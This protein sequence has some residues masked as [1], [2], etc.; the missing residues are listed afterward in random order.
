[1]EIRNLLTALPLI[2]ASTTASG[3]PLTPEERAYM[4]DTLNDLK[5]QHAPSTHALCAA[6]N[7]LAAI[8]LDGSEQ[9]LA[10]DEAKRHRD[11]AAEAMGDQLTAEAIEA[12]MEDVVSN[13]EAGQLELET[14]FDGA[15]LCREI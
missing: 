7:G 8:K 15:E 9:R 5:A 11:I 12:V 1:M 13:Y 4:M 3:E 6:W 2:V 10:I 14:L